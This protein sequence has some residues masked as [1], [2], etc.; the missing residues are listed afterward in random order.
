MS[1]PGSSGPAPIRVIADVETM[2]A[3]ADPTRIA[4]LRLLMSG[5]KADPPVMSAKQIAAALQEPQIKLYRHLKHL[6]AV[7]LIRVAETRMVSGIKEQRYQT[8]QLGL[9]IDRALAAGGAAAHALTDALVATLSDFRNNLVRHLAAGR[10]PIGPPEDTPLGMIL[11][12]GTA[13]R[14]SPAR[15]AEFRSRL[16]ALEAE[17]DDLD[18]DDPHGVPVQL[19]LGWYTVSDAS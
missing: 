10:V 1:A 4:I 18:S 15:A 11:I 9:T 12:T 16:L 3:M 19:L 14:V 5:D 7:D 2:R 6:A 17:F 13:S 8:G